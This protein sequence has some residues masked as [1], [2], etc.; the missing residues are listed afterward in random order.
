MRLLMVGDVVGRPGRD[1]IVSLLPPL[2]REQKVDL[3]VVNGENAAQGAGITR[4]IANELLAAGADCITMGN[5]T[6]ARKEIFKF[7][8][9]EPRLIRPANY[10]PGT[11]GAAYF[12]TRVG[13]RPVAVVNLMGRVFMNTVLDC[14]F[15]VGDQVL[16]EL[17]EGAVV[18][19]DFHAEATSEK[20]ALG[21]Y[22]DGRVAAVLGT[23]THV[24]TADEVVLPGGTAYQSDV[25]MTG[26]LDSI[27][28]M[29]SQVALE[30]FTTGLPRKAEVA[31]GKACLMASLVEVDEEGRAT[32]IRRLVREAS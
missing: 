17:P 26:P 2:V 22:L 24:P 25:G 31:S 4:H 27:I 13:G 5:H 3:A 29:N 18:L 32:S 12:V 20:Q 1:A 23:H 30:R 14:P 16:S 6:W 7:I 9:S 11:P 28:G 19:V 15:R 8:D 10:P 21:R